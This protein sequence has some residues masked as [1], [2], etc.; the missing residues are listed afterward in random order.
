MMAIKTPLGGGVEY[1]KTTKEKI[2]WNIKKYLIRT[3]L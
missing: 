2:L 1:K 3:R